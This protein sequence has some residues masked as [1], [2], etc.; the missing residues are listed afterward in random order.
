[1]SALVPSSN[2]SRLAVSGLRVRT[3]N[4]VFRHSGLLRVAGITECEGIEEP[5]ESRRVESAE[6]SISNSCETNSFL[7]LPPCSALQTSR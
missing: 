2:V 7:E 3:E 6:L 4:Q 5:R 1:M